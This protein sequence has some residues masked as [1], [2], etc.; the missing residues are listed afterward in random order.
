MCYSVMV[1]RYM[2]VGR[3]KW[4]WLLSHCRYC[5]AWPR[6]VLQS[7]MIP[8][9]TQIRVSNDYIP[10]NNQWLVWD[11]TILAHAMGLAAFKDVRMCVVQG[12]G[13]YIKGL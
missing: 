6:H 2:C 4:V 10:G 12:M 5:M 3:V 11:A 7:V 9:V 8:A 13:M 1:P